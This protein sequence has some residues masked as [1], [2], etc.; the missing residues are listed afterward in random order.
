M[1]LT[2]NREAS[3]KGHLE[4]RL[5]K[6]HPSSTLAHAVG[7]EKSQHTERRVDTFS[8]LTKLLRTSNS[9]SLGWASCLD[10]SPKEAVPTRPVKGPVF[11][12][13]V[14]DHHER[15][16]RRAEEK[17]A[18]RQED[19]Q[20]TGFLQRGQAS[21]ALLLLLLLVSLT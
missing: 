6:V 1:R 15:I 5:H 2:V 18:S 21:F 16:T 19:D 9:P 7:R 13:D 4:K 3:S 8:S 11:E 12:R 20:S 17:R 14:L 10:S